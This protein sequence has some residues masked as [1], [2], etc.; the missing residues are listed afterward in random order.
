M[1]KKTF[2]RKFIFD[3]HIN[4]FHLFL[5]HEISSNSLEETG[6]QDQA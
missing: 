5:D 2:F 1:K 4:S 3:P 6:G